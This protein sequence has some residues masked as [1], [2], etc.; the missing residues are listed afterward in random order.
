MSFQ[1]DLYQELSSQFVFSVCV[2]LYVF[3]I[4]F[5]DIIGTTTSFV[6]QKHIYA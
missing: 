1:V 2:Y 3:Y 4:V 6:Y 5:N